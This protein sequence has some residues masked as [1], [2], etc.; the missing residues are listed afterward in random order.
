MEKESER[1]RKGLE[2]G[3]DREEQDR[4]VSHFLILGRKVIYH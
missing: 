4:E 2:T 3:E 1:D